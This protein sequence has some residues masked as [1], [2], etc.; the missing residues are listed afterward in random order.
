VRAP[1]E[2]ARSAGGAAEPAPTVAVGIEIAGLPPFARRPP[3]DTRGADPKASRAERG[4]RDQ[5]ADRSTARA[6]A[7]PL[8]HA[9]SRPASALTGDFYLR[10]RRGD[11]WLFGLGDVAGHGLEAAVY[12][13]MIQED[14][15]RLA[16]DD[17]L[18]LPALVAELHATLRRE[19]PGSRFASLVLGELG[20]T[21]RMEIV[22]AG[23]PSPLLRRAG[24]EVFALPPNGPILGP[25]PRAR[26]S[27]LSTRLRPDDT[28]LLVSDGV[29]E[30]RSPGGEEFGT[31][32]LWSALERD[33]AL[34][35]RALVDRIL[36]DLVTFRGGAAPHDDTTIVAVRH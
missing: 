20:P 23:H 3:S 24:G 31:E 35:P 12:M 34:E 21:G 5:E 6:V 4:A 13:M 36:A 8:F 27:S 7:E 32:R 16:A 14:I 30:A 18:A 22:N 15:E 33:G 26:W 19:L 11:A 29:L 25:L 10:L 9:V 17:A 28:L 2:D 1:G